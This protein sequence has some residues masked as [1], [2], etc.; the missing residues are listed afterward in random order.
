MHGVV[1]V[2]F[3]A[4]DGSAVVEAPPLAVLGTLRVVHAGGAADVHQCAVGVA[5]LGA[6][7]ADGHVGADA[8]DHVAVIHVKAVVLAVVF[9]LALG[10]VR[11]G[12]AC[13]DNGI[14][15][16]I[17]SARGAGAA[18][19]DQVEHLAVGYGHFAGIGVDEARQFATNGDGIIVRV[20]LHGLV[21]IAQRQYVGGVAVAGVRRCPAPVLGVEGE[22]VALVRQEQEA[23]AL[24]GGDRSTAK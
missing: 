9:G 24:A 22:G 5:E 16:V 7:H 14:L 6:D 8:G 23:V 17:A 15:E 19:L 4:L 20:E 21:A 2:L 18:Q 1:G 12:E 13:Q 11:I 3:A 10:G